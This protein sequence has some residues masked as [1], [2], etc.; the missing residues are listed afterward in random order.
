MSQFSD[1]TQT[2]VDII[3][4]RGDYKIIR[5][6]Y[7]EDF[8][9]AHGTTLQHIKEKVVVPCINCGKDIS[10]ML[11]LQTS[12]RKAFVYCG[13]KCRGQHSAIRVI[14]LNEKTDIN[15]T[16]KMLIEKCYTIQLKEGLRGKP[17]RGHRLTILSALNQNNK[18][19][20]DILKELRDARKA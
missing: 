3:D 12:R 5:R 18:I 8:A 20:T 7:D 4:S 19:L 13:P 11:L 14:S 10:S 17:V 1:L 6:P 2:I 9:E 15:A 16:A